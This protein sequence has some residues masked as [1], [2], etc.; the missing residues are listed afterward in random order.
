MIENIVAMGE[1][2]VRDGNLLHDLLLNSVDRKKLWFLG[3][4]YTGYELTKEEI[5]G[6]PAAYEHDEMNLRKVCASNHITNVMR[7]LLKRD[8]HLCCLTNMVRAIELDADEPFEK[9]TDWWLERSVKLVERCEGLLIITLPGWDK[10]TG[11]AAEIGAASL[12]GKP[13]WLVNPDPNKWK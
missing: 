3:A 1:N 13:I 2:R 12:T 7:E 4:P 6:Y 5:L 11:V 10:S 8:F 9:E